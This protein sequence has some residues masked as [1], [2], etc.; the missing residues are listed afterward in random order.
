MIDIPG[1]EI[2]NQIYESSR[3]EIFRGTRLSDDL[4]V[5]AGARYRNGRLI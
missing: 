2:H 1:Y 5:S 4:P 3:S